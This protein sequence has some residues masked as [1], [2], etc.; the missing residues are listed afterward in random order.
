[1]AGSECEGRNMTQ[2]SHRTYRRQLG[3]HMAD[4]EPSRRLETEASNVWTAIVWLACAAIWM[5]PILIFLG[6]AG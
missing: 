4:A 1:M 3:L 2:L 5:V 6:A